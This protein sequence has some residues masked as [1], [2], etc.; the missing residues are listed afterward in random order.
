MIVATSHFVDAIAAPMARA[1][2]RDARQG[3][4]DEPILQ[5]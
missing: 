5:L 2:A 3:S 4:A 1:A